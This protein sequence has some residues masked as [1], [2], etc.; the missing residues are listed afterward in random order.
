M[1]IVIRIAEEKDLLPIQRLVAKAGLSEQGIENN[2]GDF[3]VVE[4]TNKQ[5]VG[6]VGI[7]RLGLDGLLR[8]L[9]I[10]T[11][12]SNAKIGLE[13]VEL[14][15]A[16]AKQQNIQNLFLLTNK[17]VQFFEYLGFEVV[18]DEEIPSHIK[19]SS[20]FKQYVKG[21]TKVLSCEL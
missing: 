9:V 10:K 6:T 13:F 8:S 14:A 12:K 5:I 11:E 7:E 17:S 15:I 2:I 4:D 3:L 16:Y 19:D 20:H 21:V 1:G 18:D